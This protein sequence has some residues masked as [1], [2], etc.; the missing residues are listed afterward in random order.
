MALDRLTADDRLVLWSDVVWPQDVGMIAL[1]EGGPLLGADGRFRLELARSAVSRRLHLLP[2]LRQVLR[3][4]G[5]GLGWPLW[6]DDPSFDI[7]EHVREARVPGPGSEAELLATVERLRRRRLG[8]ARPLWEMWFLPGLA[9]GRVGLF[10]RLHHVVADGIAGV[11]GLASL[12]DTTPDAPST[13]GPTWAPRRGPSTTDLLVDN[14]ERRAR[15][16][17]RALAA[18]ARPGRSLRGLREGWPAT[19]ELLGG[20]PGPSTSLDGLLGPSRT[21]GVA[22]SSL[23][24]VSAVARAHGATVNDVLLAMIAGGLRTLLTSRGERVDGLDLPVYVPMSVRRSREDRAMGNRISQIIV[25]LPV[26]LGDPEERLRRITATMRERKDVARPLLGTTFRSRW[27]SKPMLKLIIRQRV[28][29]VSADLIGPSAPLYLAGAQ[30]LDLFPLVNLV[31]N[32]TLG[33]AALSYA[34]RFE[35]LAVADEGRYPDLDDLTAGVS[36]ELRALA[37]AAIRPR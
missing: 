9:D 13:N 32:V 37:G 29:V 30:V 5:R 21:L 22:Q 2:R 3:R 4:P 26:G 12:L 11:A 16:L 23:A 24:D 14:L 27:L 31:G 17:G 28:N 33:V 20:E 34:G 19:R 10:V 25:P 8:T 7:S 6:V 36:E 18:V 1:L 35:V 15:G